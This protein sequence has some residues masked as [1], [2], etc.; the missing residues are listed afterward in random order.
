MHKRV[1]AER[2]AHMRRAARRRCE[3]DQIACL[4][5]SGWNIRS[6]SKLL[7][8]VP[9]QAKAD[10]GEHPLREAAAVETSRVGS[11]VAVGRAS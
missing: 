9:R 7:A 8:R 10:A 6:R 11:T 2:D 1:V 3:E 4:L 5:R